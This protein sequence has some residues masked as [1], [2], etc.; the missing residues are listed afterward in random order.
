MRRQGRSAGNQGLAGLLPTTSTYD[1]WYNSDPAPAADE[2]APAPTQTGPTDAPPPASELSD[3]A[4]S[5]VAAEFYASVK[6]GLED[7][8]RAPLGPARSDG[9]WRGPFAS[10]TEAEAALAEL[11]V[12]AVDAIC[13]AAGASVPPQTEP[14][15]DSEESDDDLD[16]ALM[17]DDEEQLE[18]VRL[19]KAAN[20]RAKR[21]AK[22]HGW[23]A[24]ANEALV[25]RVA[26]AAQVGVPMNWAAIKVLL[27]NRRADFF[28]T[29]D[30]CADQHQR[31]NPGCYGADA[32]APIELSAPD[33][34]RRRRPGAWRG[35]A[36]RGGR[37]RAAARDSLDR[38]HGLRLGARSG[39]ARALQLRHAVAPDDPRGN[40]DRLVGSRALS[41]R[42][43]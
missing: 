21:E 37:V 13:A 28:P 8:S 39:D 1:V 16:V 43:S 11:E 35:A 2:P 19:Q 3:D 9:S 31:L 10:R 42:G 18:A 40:G 17:D 30:E 4:A 7:T 22:K 38:H 26:S 20:T 29:A 24:N 6:H 34:R 41:A 14:D 23:T 32:F 15:S 33:M 27:E 12:T 5:G 25:A 36:G